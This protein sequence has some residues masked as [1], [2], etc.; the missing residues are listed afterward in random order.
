MS[1]IAVGQA[2]LLIPEY[3]LTLVLTWTW[4]NSRP[5]VDEVWFTDWITRPGNYQSGK[6]NELSSLFRHSFS[7][8]YTLSSLTN[9]VYKWWL[10]L[11]IPHHHFSP[12][13]TVYSVSWL[14]LKIYFSSSYTMTVLGCIKPC[15]S[16]MRRSNLPGL[17]ER[18]EGKSPERGE[19]NYKEEMRRWMKRDS[20]RERERETNKKWMTSGMRERME[21]VDVYR[22]YC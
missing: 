11:S 3:L 6:L 16:L 7:F 14:N 19:R 17:T 22:S 20:E 13:H 15:Y 12:L 21:R 1:I 10:S 18:V 4:G 8:P 9:H 5:K 2:I